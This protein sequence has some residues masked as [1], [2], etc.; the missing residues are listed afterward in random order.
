MKKAFTSIL[1]VFCI[2]NAN[3]WG[4][5]GHSLV[6]QVTYHHLDDATKKMF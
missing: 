4:S 6:A 3:A 2:L 1:I 5:K